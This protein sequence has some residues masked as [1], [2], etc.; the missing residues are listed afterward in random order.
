M[1]LEFVKVPY[2]DYETK[3]LSAFAT[4]ENAPDIVIGV[5]AYWAGAVVVADP[6]PAALAKRMD[7][8]VVTA[9]QP[10]F[11]MQSKWYGGPDSGV[12]GLGPMLIYNPDDFKEV[13]LDPTKPPRTMD[14]M[15]ECA[16]K[17][18]K[19]DSSGN[20]TRSG[21]AHRYD[22]ALGLGI[23]GKFIPFLHAFGG[24]IY[25]PTTGKSQGV[26]NSPEAVAALEYCVKYTQ[27]EKLSSLTFGV[28]E[29]QF[30]QHQASMMFREGHM[31]GWLP[32]NFPDVNFEFAP[33]PKAKTDGMGIT[34]VDSWGT[35]VYKFSPNREAAWDFLSTVVLTA[36]NDLASSKAVQFV[37]A[38]KANWEG[39]Y[40]RGRKDY[41]VLQYA[42][43]H[44]TGAM[45]MHP[46]NN[47]LA[48]RQALAVQEVLLGK[49]KPKEALDQ[50]AVDMEKILGG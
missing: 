4:R 24:R 11:R 19:R 20:V 10:G 41:K 18:V 6:M 38:F 45:Y 17:L 7:R 23:G 31:A 30:G 44:S 8:E 34:G 46:L 28:P 22:G 42:L 15:L 1:Q 49:K 40:I 33:I 36:E 25:D 50:A 37:P 43:T 9:L 13:G 32:K 21:F 39:E 35:L 14:E 5:I 47:K 2:A 48:D 27:T 12:V 29:V 26:T 16:R 3:F